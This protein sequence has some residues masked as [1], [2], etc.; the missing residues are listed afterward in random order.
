MTI[1]SGTNNTLTESNNNNI[2]GV[3]EGD[4]NPHHPISSS[5]ITIHDDN[6]HVQHNL[7]ENHINPYLDINL[8]NKV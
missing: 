5:V 1:I 6:Y 8:R 7:E 2:N 4:S 3:S